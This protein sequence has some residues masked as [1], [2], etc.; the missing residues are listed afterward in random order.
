MLV[1]RLAV[2]DLDDLAE[3]HHRDVGAEVTDHREVVGDEQEGDPELLLHV[4]QQVDHLGLDRHVE[5]GN[6]LVRDQQLGLEGQGTGDADALPLTTGE[7]ARVA[8]V[9]LGV[10]ADH[11]EQLLDPGQDLLLRHHLVHAQRGADDRAHRVTRVQ[12]GVRILEDHLDLAPDRH[13][14]PPRETRD[15]GALEVDRT[16]RRVVEPG[17]QA[18]GGGLAT[19][20]LPHQA[21]RLALAQREGHPVDRLDVCDGTADDAAGLHREVL[22]QVT[23]LEQ[24]ITRRCPGVFRGTLDV[25]VGHGAHPALKC[26]SGRLPPAPGSSHRC[27]GRSGPARSPA[28]SPPCRSRPDWGGDN[29]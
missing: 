8:V 5:R 20:G 6:G 27:W 2:T 16:G 14:L 24:G 29:A 9:V 19:P 3:I 21:E 25:C 17:D 13:H 26:R 23:D 22:G 7:L 18:T 28:G 15:V 1:D 10:E 4:L 11:L 12:R